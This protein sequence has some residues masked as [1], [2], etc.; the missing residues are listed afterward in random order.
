MA[1]VLAVTLSLLILEPDMPTRKPPH[2]APTAPAP[3]APKASARTGRKPQ[4]GPDP[5]A[6]ALWQAL[7]P[8]AAGID[9]GAREIC[10][11]VPPDRDAQPVRTFE[12]FTDSLRELAVVAIEDSEFLE[13]HHALLGFGGRV[14]ALFRALDQA[15]H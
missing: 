14:V 3:A 6:A 9:I 1:P 15:A 7:N 8:H 10:V 5:A 11:C 4:A 12:T 13:H 2:P